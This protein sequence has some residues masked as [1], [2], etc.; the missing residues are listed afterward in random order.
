MGWQALQ[1]CLRL[2]CEVMNL[3]RSARSLAQWL[4]LGGLVGA[5]CGGASALFLFLLDEATAL[6]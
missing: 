6:R 1:A 5:V 4:L 2:H 3:S